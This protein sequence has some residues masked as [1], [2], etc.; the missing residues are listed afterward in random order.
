MAPEVGSE[1]DWAEASAVPV[2]MAVE[3]VHCLAASV[4]Q[5]LVAT[6]LAEVWVE[7]KPEV[8]ARP[9]VTAP[10][11]ALKAASEEDLVTPEASAGSAI[12]SKNSLVSRTS[13]FE[14]R[15]EYRR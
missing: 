9:A 14:Q 8:V 1:E 6:A 10:V 2:G 13:Y 5:V 7:V 12:T 15:E 4:A 3:M 11:L